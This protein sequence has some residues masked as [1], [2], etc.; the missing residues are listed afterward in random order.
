[1]IVARAAANDAPVPAAQSAA[2]AAT[3]AKGEH[4]YRLHGLLPTPG[5][6]LTSTP[7]GSARPAST[8]AAVLRFEQR[9]HICAR[10]FRPPRRAT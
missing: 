5:V 10:P 4:A 7:A 3:L 6:L 1:M 8:A 2:G 9:V